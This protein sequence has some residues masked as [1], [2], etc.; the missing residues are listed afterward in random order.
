MTHRNRFVW[1]KGDVTILKRK[2]VTAADRAAARAAADCAWT[3]ALD[4]HPEPDPGDRLNDE[5]L[6]SIDSS[7]T[8]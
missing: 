7:I 6:A 2:A 5:A 8:K 4:V 1:T 3:E